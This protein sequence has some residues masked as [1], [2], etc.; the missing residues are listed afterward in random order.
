M[1]LPS[2]MRR[3]ADRAKHAVRRTALIYRCTNR[4]CLEEYDARPRSSRERYPVDW[5]LKCGAP[6]KRRLKRD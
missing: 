3:S 6:L 5:C 2:E 1:T 4:R